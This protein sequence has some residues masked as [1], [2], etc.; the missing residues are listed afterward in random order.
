[1]KK[2]LSIL[3]AVAITASGATAV[4]ACSTNAKIND[5][6]A[7]IPNAFALNQQLA[8]EGY[9]I[10]KLQVKFLPGLKEATIR[11]MGQPSEAPFVTKTIKIN[12]VTNDISK[13]IT[14]TS[15]A[16][17]AFEEK[18]QTE[19]EIL[20]AINLLNQTNLTTNEV[21]INYD[22]ELGQVTLTGIGDFNGT[23][24]IYDEPM[25]WSDLIPFQNLGDIYFSHS[26]I[27]YFNE[28]VSILEED[29]QSGATVMFIMPFVL[30]F[31]GGKN[32]LMEFFQ[33]QMVDWGKSWMSTPNVAKATFDSNYQ[34]SFILTP[35]TNKIFNSGKMTFSFNAID[36][37]RDYVTSTHKPLD[38]FEKGHYTYI[39]ETLDKSYDANNIDEMAKDLVEKYFGEDFANKYSSILNEEFWITNVDYVKKTAVLEVKPGSM[40][41]YNHDEEL[42]AVVNDVDVPFYAY[43]INVT[44][45]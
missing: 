11:Y 6:Y 38:S 26:V 27:D 45:G 43:K 23:V 14:K 10:E 21:K 1:M 36:D 25:E 44:F 8:K 3:G 41:F 18:K 4:V 13:I 37:S 15:L 32:L 19:S 33:K 22:K 7:V 12:P 29:E 40:L 9:S 35:P 5:S 30:E 39:E 17:S 24:T 2:L 28:N 31:V 16:I 42:L 34:G 20:R